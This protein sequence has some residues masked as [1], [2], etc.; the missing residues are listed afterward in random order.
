[1]E[2]SFIKVPHP[3]KEQSMG[4][5]FFCLNKVAQ[6]RCQQ[7]YLKLA[8]VK[9]LGRVFPCRKMVFNVPLLCGGRYFYYGVGMLLQKLSQICMY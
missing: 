9:L 8:I 2:E 1:L 7:F 4:L 6:H 3:I 5:L